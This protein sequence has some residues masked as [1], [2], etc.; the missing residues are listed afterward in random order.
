MQND[1]R[2]GHARGLACAKTKKFP[3]IFFA[4]PPPPLRR[5]AEKEMER[6]FL[7]LLRRFSLRKEQSYFNIFVCSF[8][9]PHGDRSASNS[10]CAK[11]Q[12]NLYVLAPPTQCAH[13]SPPFLEKIIKCLGSLPLILLIIKTQLVIN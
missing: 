9:H 5:E 1:A 13:K 7:V 12:S 4:P 8:L 6:K 2:L 3:C 11:A 10:V